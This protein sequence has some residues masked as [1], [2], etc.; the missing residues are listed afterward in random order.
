[1]KT[2]VVVAVTAT[3]L[4][5]CELGAEGSTRFADRGIAL[6]V[7]SGWSVTGFS[8]DVTP[9]RLVAASYDVRPDDV[10]G[11]CG[12]QA[13][14][15][16]LRTDGAYVVLIDYGSFPGDLDRDDFSD[17][18]PTSGRDEPFRDERFGEFGCFGPS[19]VFLF[20][21]GDRALQAHV[22][23]GS[24]ATSK[25]REE[26]LDVLKIQSLA[27]EPFRPNRPARTRGVRC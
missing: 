2:L 3:A 18:L 6:K 16:Q 11:D 20:V 15:E 1:M 13:A 8:K 5:A 9:R 21:V 14:V 4:A 19:Y 12:G 10:E 26:A 27:P 22:G 23:I 7:P 25:R 17:D 24:D